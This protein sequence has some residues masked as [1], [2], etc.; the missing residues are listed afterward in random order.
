MTKL[1]ELLQVISKKVVFIQTHNYPDQ[2][3]LATAHGLKILLEHFGKQAI[4]CYKGEIDKY[5]TIKMIELLKLDITPADSIEFREDDETIL[6]DCQRGNSNV[7]SYTGKVIGCIDHHTVQSNYTY[8]FQDIR[9]EYGACATIIVDYFI[10]NNIPIDTLLATALT[11]AIRM[12]T[13]LLSRSVTDTDMRLYSQLYHSSDKQILN[14]LDSCNM[15]IRDL[16]VYHQAIENLRLY[17][18]IALLDLGPD[19][20]EA[21]MGQ[22]SDFML[23]LREV[24][25]II[26]HSYRDGGVK[27]TVR[28]SRKELDASEIVRAA[29]IT[30]GDGGGHAT[31][32]AGFVP[33]IPSNSAALTIAGIA[34]ERT[35]SY[36]CNIMGWPNAKRKKFKKIT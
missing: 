24:D 27:F 7:K 9:P 33:N 31:M 30:I 20:S 4:V 32:A 25:L 28:S 2:D 11:Y 26:T 10:E 35:I 5:N 17:H 19:C 22:I 3:A 1:Q 13:N 12:D 14:Q 8:L 23:T 21:L 6:V 36:V 34:E 18:S 15:K 16:L 29:L